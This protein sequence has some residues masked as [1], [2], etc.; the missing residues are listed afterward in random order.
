ME[1]T[2]CYSPR[3]AGTRSALV[4]ALLA[5]AALTA[6]LASCSSPRRAFLSGD[7][8][9]RAE[10]EEL[11]VLLDKSGYDFVQRFAAIRQISANFIEQGE[12]GRLTSFLTSILGTTTGGLDDPYESWYYFTLAYAYDRSGSAPIA[13]IYYDRVLKNWPDA[14]VDG[15]S[16]HNVCLSRLIEIVHSSER[17][18]EYYKDMIAR[19]P[20]EAESGKT[21]FLLGKE[22]ERV[23]DWDKAVDAYSRFI[24]HYGET[25]PGHPDAF[26]YARGI[27]DFYNSPKDW[28][29][30]D[31]GELVTAIKT[32]LSTG[33]AQKLR[34]YRAKVNFFAVDWLKRETDPSSPALF[35]FGEF[36]SGGS[37]QSAATLDPAS[38]GREAYL[39]T[40]GW[41][42][43]ISTWYFCFRKVYFPADPEIHGRWEWAGI[44]YGE[45]I[46]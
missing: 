34:A 31:L 32:A 44:Y 13:A 36:M 28:C 20:L 22:Y 2:A 24:P 25:V 27:V 5:V 26:G 23:G 42:D 10:L 35:D 41:T 45:K 8:I 3:M 19:F 18:I 11:F 46:Q 15:R 17:R 12:F 40:W 4:A 30:A 16:I 38:S 6:S 21:L 37:I 43:R 14:A 39:K 29:F 9:Q 33:N 1:K 7:A